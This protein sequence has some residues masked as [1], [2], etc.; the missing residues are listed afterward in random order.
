M[1]LQY[2]ETG[3]E[4]TPIT[5]QHCLIETGHG[6]LAEKLKRDLEICKGKVLLNSSVVSVA[7]NTAAELNKN[8]RVSV[9]IQNGTESSTLKGEFCLVTASLGVLK[10]RNSNG[11]KFLPEL[12]EKKLAAIDRLG[13][14]TINT[15]VLVFKKCH[16]DENAPTVAY[17]KDKTSCFTVENIFPSTEKPALVVTIHGPLAAEIEKKSDE[18]ATEYCLEI[19][20]SVHPAIKKNK[21][22]LGKV[23][24]WAKDKFTKGAVTH[25]CP[26]SSPHDMDTLAE[27]VDDYLFFAGEA[28]HSIHFATTQGAMLSGK[29]EANKIAHVLAKR[30]KLV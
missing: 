19:A 1:S 25:L 26:G 23:T 4:E 20:K 21:P 18:E 7:H 10:D 22:L 30:K 15:V 17:V 8:E 24:R 5:G 6:V 2:W 14:D 29:R 28:T 9:T 13:F 3:E 27:P 12:N 11:I 16:W